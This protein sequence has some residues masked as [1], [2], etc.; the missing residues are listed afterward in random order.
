MVPDH[1]ILRSLFDAAIAAAQP[2][3]KFDGRLP[4][5]P[6]GRTI[7]VGAGKAASSMA[8]AFEA[9]WGPCEGLVVTRYGHRTRT[10][11][12][13]V[14]EAAHP[15]PDAAGLAAADRILALTQAA[16]SDDL[17]VCLMSGGASALLTRPAPGISLEA[18]QAITR[19]LLRSGAPIG[20][21]NSI[22]KTLSSIKGGRLAA[23]AA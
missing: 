22:R 15:V 13:E 19:D 20:A 2:A 16:G 5:R 3:G 9:A 7:V 14:V 8:G 11:F 18:K 1:E 21:M 23:A 17:V 10:R 12:I 6:R 4:E